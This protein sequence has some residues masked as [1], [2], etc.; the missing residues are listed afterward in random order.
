MLGRGVCI[1]LA[2]AQQL[3]LLYFGLITCFQNETVE[4]NV[5]SVTFND[6]VL[7]LTTARTDTRDN[8]IELELV[9]TPAVDDTE[10]KISNV[11]KEK[12][13]TGHRTTPGE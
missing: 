4:S 13:D 2:T 5:T 7:F 10:Q 9:R 6:T 8:G 11:Q 3:L 12:S 1:N